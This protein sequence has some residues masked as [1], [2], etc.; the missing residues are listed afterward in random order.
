MCVAWLGVAWKFNLLWVGGVRVAMPVFW[1]FCKLF[2]SN[3]VEYDA[4][5]TN[6]CTPI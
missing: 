6:C 1:Y 2:L 4:M 5:L 3:L